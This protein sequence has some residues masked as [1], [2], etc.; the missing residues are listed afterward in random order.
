MTD[1]V[2]TSMPAQA[3]FLL[4]RIAEDAKA[5]RAVEESDG[6]LRAG[7]PY[8]DGSGVA[9]RDD[10]PQYPWGQ[11][12]ADSAFLAGVGH[13]S[14]VLADCAAKRAIV[15]RYLAQLGRQGDPDESQ[16]AAAVCVAEYEGWVIP[17]LLD[18][19]AAY[20]EFREEWR[21]VR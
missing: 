14:R 10:F 5:A 20:P 9:D 16:V 21:W 4:A 3:A 2:D 6:T 7:D 11:S 12:A 17:A 8:P 1:V 18:A 19:Y 13:P 15:E